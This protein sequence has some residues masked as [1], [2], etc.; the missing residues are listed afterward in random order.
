MRFSGSVFLHPGGPL[1]VVISKG[2]WYNRDMEKID[3]TGLS[4]EVKVYISSLESKVPALSGG[5]MVFFTV[6]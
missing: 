3:V 5:S 6:K 1:F 2:L 4:P